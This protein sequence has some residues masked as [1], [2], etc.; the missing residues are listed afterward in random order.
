MEHTYEKLI[1][2][3]MLEEWQYNY[4]NTRSTSYYCNVQYGII[5]YTLSYYYW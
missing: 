3:Y 1:I 4:N 2:S 5:K